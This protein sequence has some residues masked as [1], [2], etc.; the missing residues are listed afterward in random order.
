MTPD[1][2]EEKY[3][4]IDRRRVRF[5]VAPPE[6]A[7]GVEP[8][9]SRP[10]ELPTLLLHGLGCS[11]KVWM[12]TIRE[13]ARQGLECPVVAPDMPGYGRSKGPRA[14][15]GIDELADWAVRFLDDRKLGRVHLAG[16]SMGCQVALAL[17][18]R[19]PDRVGGVV[20]QGATTGD[21]LVPPWRYTLGL[22][23]DAFRE[24]LK[25]NARLS[26]MYVQMGMGR[27]MATVR[28]MLADDP[29]GNAGK[30]R[31]PVLVIRGGADAIVPDE[32]ARHL[33]AALPDAVYMPLDSA[34]HA[35]EYNDPKDF[36]TALVNFLGRAEEKLGIASGPA[37]SGLLSD[38]QPTSTERA[39]S[40]ATAAAVT[41][42]I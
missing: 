42:T 23:A 3:T 12:P 8:A 24:S 16:N 14:T 37:E 40:H 18:R 1:C 31:A 11:G 41:T 38:D 17:A 30:V 32:V 10:L 21:R 9:R 35:I 19:H 20:L 7:E 15:L 33:T 29:I 28:K 27:Y 26:V 34:A 4:D 39:R 36:A 13:M 6:R 2:A 25:Y 22:L 5:I